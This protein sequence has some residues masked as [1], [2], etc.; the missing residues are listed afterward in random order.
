MDDCCIDKAGAVERLRKRQAETLRL[1]LLANAAMFGIGLIS[2]LF[3]G[4]VA[5]LAD[6]L[7]MLGDA[8][9]YVFLANS[10]FAVI[11]VHASKTNCRNPSIFPIF[12][13]GNQIEAG[14]FKGERVSPTHCKDCPSCGLRK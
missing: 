4:S 5:L 13:R 12:K 6:S 14:P 11:C 7:D 9:V 1:V 2:G 8:L 3:A 10:K